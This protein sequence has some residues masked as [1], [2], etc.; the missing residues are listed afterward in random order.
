[1]KAV[2]VAL[3]LLM[4]GTACS[5]AP[6]G[7]PAGS[8]VAIQGFLFDPEELTVA[9]GASVTWVNGDEILHTV[10]GGAPGE[11]TGRFDGQLPAAGDRFSFTFEQVG[12]YAYFCSRHHHMRGV[13]VVG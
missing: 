5:A 7:E 10:T 11:E 12:S 1:M 4:L 2:A 6:E 13:I 8:D 3:A 9:A